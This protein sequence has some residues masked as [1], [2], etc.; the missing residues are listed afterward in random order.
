MQWLVDYLTSGFVSLLGENDLVEIWAPWVSRWLVTFLILVLAW[1]MNH[2]AKGFM[3]RFLRFCIKN[4]KTQ[5]D[6]KLVQRNLFH[7]LSHLAPIIV[8]SFFLPQIWVGHPTAEGLIDAFSQIYTML[9]VLLVVQALLDAFHDVYRTFE[10]SKQVPIYSFIQ[11]IKLIVYMVGGVFI[12][13]KLMGKDPSVI[14]GSLG[15]LTAV[16][17]LVFKDSILGFAAGIH[18]TTNKMLSLG[19]WLEMPKYGADGDVIEIGLTTVKVQNFDKTITTIPTY[20]LISDAFKNWRGMSE[21]PGRRIKRSILIDLH[22]IRFCDEA[23]LESLASIQAIS[24]YIREKQKEVQ[25]FN[26]QL[27][28]GGSDHPANGRRLTNIGTFRAYL[29]AFLR[30]H[31]LINQEM[32]LLVRQ[33]E[34]TP[35]GLPLQIYVFSSDKRWVEYEGIVS[36]LFDHILSVMKEFDLRAYQEPSGLDFR[37]GLAR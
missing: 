25:A 31:P 17:M 12:V 27:V 2:L 8:I 6:D 7:R 36:D 13:A 20:T 37:Q 3:L 28:T 22:S 9:V 26:Q 23:L 18:L 30:Q 21:S 11:A 33:L 24:G 32:T 14:F 29:V 4:S 10:W 1:L 16:L 5:W 34:P 19:D 15:A 35:R